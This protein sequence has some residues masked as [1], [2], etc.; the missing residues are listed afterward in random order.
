MKRTEYFDIAFVDGLA[1]GWIFGVPEPFRDQL[2]IRYSE[3]VDRKKSRKLREQTPRNN[4]D[5]L[6]TVYRVAWTHGMPPLFS[7]DIGHIFYDPPNA[8]SMVWGD[9]VRVLRRDVQVTEARP[10]ELPG[11][12]WVKVKIR[13]FDGG[14]VVE[15]ISRN[16]PQGE[17]VTFL[18]TGRL[19]AGQEPDA[20]RI[21]P[22]ATSIT[23]VVCPKAQDS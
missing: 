16:M 19:P 7:F 2:D 23:S 4:I 20:G 3:L 9:A 1:D 13:Y 14:K 8:R 10:D 15:T 6:P 11:S 5:S 18:R 12:G 17:F 22:L 21:L